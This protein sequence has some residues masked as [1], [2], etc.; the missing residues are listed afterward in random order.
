MGH[1]LLGVLG[2]NTVTSVGNGLFQNVF[3]PRQSDISSVVPLP[4]YTLEIFRAGTLVSSSF[5]YDGVQFGT[6]GMNITPNQDLRFTVGAIA[7]AQTF[8]D[9]TSVSFPTS[10]V[11]PFIYDTT[12]V[13]LAGVANTKIENLTISIDNQLEGIPTLN[14]TQYVGKIR[15]TGPP[16]VRVSGTIDFQDLSEYNDFQAQTERQLIVSFF[17]AASFQMIID[18]PRFVYTAVPVQAAGRGRITSDFT[19]M[20]RYHTGSNTALEIKL[21]TVNT[22]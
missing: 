10:P 14:N 20:A 11:E 16:L 18:V 17:K 8:I 2:Q 15:R 1:F 6:L 21:T 19:G 4:S 22:Y 12:S 5:Q 3:T 7:R 13:T 9:N